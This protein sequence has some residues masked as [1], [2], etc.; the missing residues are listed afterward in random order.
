MMVMPSNHTGTEV[1][2]LAGRHDGLVG[3]LFSPTFQRGPWP[4]LPYALDNGAFGCWVKKKPFNV[5]AWRALM[6]WAAKKQ[7]PPLWCLV[8][9]VVT[10]RAATLAAWE[11]FAP[12]AAAFGWPLAFAVQDGM[13]P[14]DVPGGA[15][16]VFIGGSKPWKWATVH[17]WCRHFARVHVGR[18]NSKRL[19]EICEGAGAESCDGTGWFM[20]DQD[21]TRGLYEWLDEHDRKRQRGQGSWWSAPSA[22]ATELSSKS[23]ETGELA[24]AG[25]GN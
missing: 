10:D 7:Q 1:G 8:P 3:L 18:V 15:S 17:L 23:A 5:P 22:A 24:P 12:E 6:A 11:Q 19:L 14:S 25:A 20:G 21:Q 2:Y 16:V 9:D 13:T 4:F